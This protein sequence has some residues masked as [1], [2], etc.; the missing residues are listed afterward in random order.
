VVSCCRIEDLIG[1]VKVPLMY[2]GSFVDMTILLESGGCMIHSGYNY[3][4]DMIGLAF[5]SGKCRES[6]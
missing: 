5:A 6:V 4:I 1:S 3:C 2:K